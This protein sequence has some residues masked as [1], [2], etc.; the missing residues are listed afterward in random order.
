MNS[1]IYRVLLSFISILLLSCPAFSSSGYI[2]PV[3][4]N[5]ENISPVS[6]RGTIKNVTESILTIQSENKNNVKSINKKIKLTTKTDMFAEFG[7]IINISDMASGQY[8]WIWYN[9]N[10][11]K[12][13]G[14][15][16]EAAT[17]IVWSTDPK[18]QPSDKDK[19][20][21]DKKK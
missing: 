20:S 2:L 7:G 5:R 11:I 12:N 8:V 19:K 21:Y 6:I 18:D 17:V 9:S 15:P 4:D 1:I 13:T 16:T 14:T 10:N 3:S